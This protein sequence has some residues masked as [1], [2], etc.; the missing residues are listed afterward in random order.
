MIDIL[1]IAVALLT[2]AFGLFGLIAPRYTAGVL[3]LEVGATTMGLSEL[4][5]SAGGLFVALG[6]IAL[7]TGSA[8]VYAGLGIAYAGACIGRLVSMVAD[9]PPQPK[10]ALYFAFEA[11]GAAWLLAIHGSAI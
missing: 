4:R 10:A 1:N 11:V 7:I 6:G 5:A 3:D 9:K 2:I 8:A